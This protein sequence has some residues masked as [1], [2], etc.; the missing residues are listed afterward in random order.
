[1][2][3]GNACT[4][5]NR[6]E[7]ASWSISLETQPSILVL[8]YVEGMDTAS[9][10]G[11]ADI[12]FPMEYIAARRKRIDS[13]IHLVFQLQCPT[14]A[15]LEGVE[16]RHP[17]FLLPNDTLRLSGRPGHWSFKGRTGSMNAYLKAKAYHMHTSSLIG[18][19][20]AQTSMA[21]SL[22]ALAETVDSIST[23]EYR[24]LE[25][26]QATFDLPS[27]FVDLERSETAYFGAVVKLG[28][29][30]YR[31]SLLGLEETIPEGYHDFLDELPIQDEKAILS[32]YY[33]EYLA[34]RSHFYSMNDSLE[35]ISIA[36]RLPTVFQT[37]LDF[38]DR[39]LQ[40]PIRDFSRLYMI[41]KAVI[42]DYPLNQ[43]HIDAAISR[44]ESPEHR[45]HLRAIQ[46][47][48]AQRRLPKG[49]KAPGFQ[50]PDTG[51][52]LVHLNDFQGRVVLLSFWAT[53]CKPCILEF[54]FENALVDEFEQHPFSL[55]SICLGSNASTWKKT[56]QKHPLKGNHLFADEDQRQ[57]LSDRYGI[58]GL[59]H[60]VLIDADGHI[61]E[62]NCLRPSELKLKDQL[63]IVLGSLDH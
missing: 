17:V 6:E 33:L 30:G 37:Q 40:P 34:Q 56:L 50:L 25:A 54:P 23:E 13:T 60:Y 12:R 32:L 18:L 8:P 2:V 46:D 36:E 15:Q 49:D 42:N 61:V 14:Y 5:N 28:A 62:N 4:I 63:N 31:T 19:K 58:G 9:I 26:S 3:F 11:Q 39:E 7:E 43:K 16:I 35:A 44:L 52:R 29:P 38:M 22:E 41:A 45:E 55:V 53:W 47:E 10:R 48:K 27:W 57:R 20:G 51:N 1:M 59:P 24:F 21:T